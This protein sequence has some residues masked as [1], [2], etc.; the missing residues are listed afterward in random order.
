M[1]ISDAKQERL[2]MEHKILDLSREFKGNTGLTVMSIDIKHE[3]QY[4]DSGYE[5]YPIEIKTEI[6]L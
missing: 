4:G 1:T 2:K 6:L 5:Y 3:G